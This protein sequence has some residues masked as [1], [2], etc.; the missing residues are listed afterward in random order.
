MK[1][2]IIR[3]LRMYTAA[4]MCLG[5]LG[6][7][8]E[9]ASLDAAPTPA[10]AREEAAVT[11]EALGFGDRWIEDER[12]LWT[13]DDGQGGQK[14]LGIGEAGRVHALRSLSA[15]EA[16]LERDL[17]EQDPGDEE[18]ELAEL[19]GFIAAVAEAPTRPLEEEPTLRCSFA[20]D[21]T[22]D[23]KPIA[24]GAA[25]AASATFAHPCGTTQGTVQTYTKASCGYI[26]NTQT[27]GPKTADPAACTSS[28][29]ITGAGPC[30]SYGFAKITGPGVSVY[31][32][33]QND[34]R[35]ACGGGTG[36][37]GLPYP[38][39]CPGINVECYEH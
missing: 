22:V 5:A 35:G 10:E 2:S 20:V 23:A 31:I 17:A 28:T 4:A 33:D 3:S 14:F 27:C 18:D 13:L 8:D 39:Q 19:R 6:A 15:V 16:E 36:T 26:T 34:L 29:S 30:S 32:W 1:Q 21:A 37:S 38:N 24:C 7:C 11:P 12:G 25:A 9:D